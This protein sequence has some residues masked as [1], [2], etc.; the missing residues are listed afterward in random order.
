MKNN[1]IL[2]LMGG[3]YHGTY[4][5]YLNYQNDPIGTFFLFPEEIGACYSPSSKEFLNDLFEGK[6]SNDPK[7][8]QHYYR[9]TDIQIN[10]ITWQYIG[11]KSFYS[12]HRQFPDGKINDKG[13]FE[14]A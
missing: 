9:I 10:Q 5:N 6:N 11:A 13:Y 1:M 4:E 8:M 2:K 14:H 7:N 12:N 3:P